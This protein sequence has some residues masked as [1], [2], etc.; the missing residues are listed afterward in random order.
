MNPPRPALDRRLLELL[1]AARDQGDTAARAEL[2]AL[3]RTDPA[4]RAAVARLLVDEFALSSRLREDEL[5]ALLDHDK[6]LP[7]ASAAPSSSASAVPSPSHHRSWW[8]WAAAALCVLGLTTFMALRFLPTAAIAANEPMPVAVLQEQ[9]D[10]VWRDTPLAAGAALTPGPR[11]LESGLVALEFTNGARLLIEGP[12]EFELLSSDHV[13]FKSGSLSAE[14]P[15]PAKG[16]TI[17]TS[18]MRVVDLG[19]RFGMSISPTGKGLVRVEKGEVEVHRKV[20]QRNL[21]QGDAIAFD[22]TGDVD[23]SLF[24]DYLIPSEN[25]LRERLASADSRR[26]ARWRSSFN[27]LAADPATLFSYDFAP[28]EENARTSDSRASAFPGQSA[29]S[30][31]GAAW[32]EGRWPGKSAVELRG[33]AD[34]LRLQCPGSHPALTLLCWLRVDS[35]PNDFNGLLLPGDYLPGSIQWMIR[36]DGQLRFSL[37]NGLASPGEYHAWEKHVVAPALTPLDFGRW[38]FLATTYDSTSGLV[39]HYRDG[40]PVGSDKITRPLPAVLGSMGVGNWANSRLTSDSQRSEKNR[41]NYRNLVGRLDELTVLSRA[42]SAE[43]LALYYE[44]G[45]P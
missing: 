10:A 39:R 44:S 29:V 22:D 21:L 43:E 19:T 12:A 41:S 9:A 25:D 7:F 8:A 45:R 17:S 18:E 20:G 31:V 40:R 6:V 24:P 2:N 4:A 35:L 32:T 36:K 5:V 13:F 42:L 26:T 27:R 1:H 38:T 30:L 3:L 14:V 34:R 15:P 11:T 37:F 16:F 33:P 28:S 23:A